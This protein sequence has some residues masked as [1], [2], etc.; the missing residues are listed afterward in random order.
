[1]GVRKA[2]IGTNETGKTSWVFERVKMDKRVFLLRPDDADKKFEQLKPWD[3]SPDKLPKV[4]EGIVNITHPLRD[5]EYIEKVLLA[6][7]EVE[8][9]TIWIDEA[10]TT[11]G[12]REELAEDLLRMSSR[13]KKNNNIYLLTHS[14][15][16]LTKGFFRNLD[17]L[18][19]KRVSDSFDGLKGRVQNA[20]NLEA[21]IRYVNE[22]A[23]EDPY[24]W[25]EYD[26]SN[27]ENYLDNG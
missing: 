2:I 26:L 15:Q 24:F 4:K 6:L 20:K 13:D 10:T 11:F 19:L 17:S 21:A 23:E 12:D 16:A 1:M 5:K 7:S 22:K 9:A 3:Q 14:P 8:G 25:I 27:P 18:I